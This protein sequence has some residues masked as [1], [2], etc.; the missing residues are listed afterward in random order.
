MDY[1]FSITVSTRNLEDLRQELRKT[2]IHIDL[3][4]VLSGRYSYLYGRCNPNRFGELRSIVTR[5]DK[6]PPWKKPSVG[7]KPHMST[8]PSINKRRKNTQ[9]TVRI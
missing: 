3:V 1:A 2:R 4:E 6:R 8:L 7:P 9:L 5:V